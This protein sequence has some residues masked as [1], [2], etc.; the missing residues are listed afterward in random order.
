M[1]D[2]TPITLS[3]IEMVIADFF[4]STFLLSVLF[5]ECRPFFFVGL[6]GRNTE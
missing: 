2:T 1:K 4:S 6:L 5:W 3:R